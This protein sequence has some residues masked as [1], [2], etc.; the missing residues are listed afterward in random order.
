MKRAMIG[1]KGFPTLYGGIER[2]VEELSKELATKGH[3]VLVYAR[4]WYSPTFSESFPGIKVIVTP[5]IRTKHLDAILHTLTS[6]IHAILQKPDVI[7]YHG[8]GPSL[9]SWIPRV[10]SPSTTVIT[11][12]HC[13]DRYHQKWGAI[14]KFFLKLGERAACTF[15]HQTIAVSKTIQNYCLNE[16]HK[17][18]TFI[19]NGVR[20]QVQSDVSKLKAWNLEPNK[21]VLAVTRLVKHKGV[22]YLIKAWQAAQRQSPLLLHPY[23]LVIVGDSA[24]TDE[25]VNKLKTLAKSDSSII[26]TGWQNGEALNALYAN[27]R[28][29]V[30]PSENEG[31]PLTILQAMAAGRAVLVSDIPEHQEV[32]SDSRFWFENASVISLTHKLVTLLEQ[33]ELLD[34]AGASNKTLALANYQWAD[35]AKKVENLYALSPAR[36]FTT[37][38]LKTVEI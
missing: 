9:L 21:Y 28:L 10:F 8:V 29:L 7:H 35:I 26:F 5:T 6:T 22:H 2:H 15:A 25:Y 33:P 20:E 4:K 17:T 1:Q 12:F 27:T 30:H 24:F 37:T 11:T 18:T 36:V 38:K 19:P 31:L 16:Y 34:S 13:L 23:K 3:Q 32:I 14:A